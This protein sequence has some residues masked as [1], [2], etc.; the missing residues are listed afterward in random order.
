MNIVIKD[1]NK[2]YGKFQALK[3]I[4]LEIKPGIF[5]LLGPNG[6]GK[7]TFIRIL[8]TLINCEYKEM[9]FGDINWSDGE[10]IRKILGYLPQKFSMYKNLSIK[11]ALDHIGVLKGVNNVDEEVDKCVEKV[12]LS[13][14]RKKKIKALSGGMLRRFGI[15]QAILGNPKL[16]II[17]EPTSGLDLEER[18]NFRNLLK[19]LSKDTTIIMSTH[20]V[21]D[22]EAIC[23]EVAILNKGSLLAKGTIEE[24]KKMVEN[25]DEP[26]LEDTYLYIIKNKG[27]KVG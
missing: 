10:S 20:I 4:S 15:A 17:D 21:E 26:T 16:L 11:D 7:T 6:A 25:K 13:K 14:E 24:L 19:D 27:E 9:T 8:A 1:L 5:G 2:Y 22:I 12:N 3:N 23:D 18:V